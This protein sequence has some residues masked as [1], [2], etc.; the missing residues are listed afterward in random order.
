MCWGGGDEGS[1]VVSARKG[2]SLCPDKG[3]VHGPAWPR[4]E[5]RSAVVMEASYDLSGSR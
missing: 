1:E 3:S 5:P 4:G 2:P